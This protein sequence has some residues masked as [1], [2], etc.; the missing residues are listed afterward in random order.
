MLRQILQK[1]KAR[2]LSETSFYRR[3]GIAFQKAGT[4]DQ[5]ILK[6]KGDDV[7]IDWGYL[8]MAI[9]QGMWRRNETRRNAGHTS[10]YF[11]GF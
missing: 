8:Y 1:I 5:S 2:K 10:E 7:R 3:D 11:Q 6:R 9:R 4:K